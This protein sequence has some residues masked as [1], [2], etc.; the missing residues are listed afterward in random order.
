MWEGS[1]PAGVVAPDG[2]VEGVDSDSRV[3]SRIAEGYLDIIY[4][5]TL[6][7]DAT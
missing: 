1:N 7:V 6:S 2:R 3:A 4:E 5:R